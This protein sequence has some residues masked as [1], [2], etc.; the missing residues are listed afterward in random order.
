MHAMPQR[1]FSEARTSFPIRDVVKSWMVGLEVNTR[2]EGAI[3]DKIEFGY[4]SG[5]PIHLMVDGEKYVETMP[6]RR[7]LGLCAA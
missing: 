6:I 2:I 3:R 4:M 7:L 5:E 1:D